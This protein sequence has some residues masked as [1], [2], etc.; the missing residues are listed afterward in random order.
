[1]HRGAFVIY[2]WCRV[3]NSIIFNSGSLPGQFWAQIMIPRPFFILENVSKSTRDEFY[4]MSKISSKWHLSSSTLKV[5]FLKVWAFVCPELEICCQAYFKVKVY[6]SD[7]LILL[8]RMWE[9]N[10]KPIKNWWFFGVSF[11][12]C[13]ASTQ[14][15]CR[16]P[17]KLLFEQRLYESFLRAPPEI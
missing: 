13:L 8:Y 14:R 15:N 6:S 1:M 4:M 12:W 3:V 7:Q 16:R 10:E 5:E 17:R 9:T 2:W 11:C